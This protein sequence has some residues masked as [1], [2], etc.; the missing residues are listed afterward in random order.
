MKLFGDGNL[1]FPAGILDVPEC[2]TD[3]FNSFSAPTT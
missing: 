2:T 3:H 1:A